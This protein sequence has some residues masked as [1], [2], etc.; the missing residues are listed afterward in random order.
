MTTITITLQDKK[1]FEETDFN[2]E[3]SPETYSDYINGLKTDDKI[4]PSYNFL[5]ACVV[6]DE[7]DALK[8][9]LK[10][11]GM[12]ILMAQKVLE[13]YMPDVDVLVKK[14]KA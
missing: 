9:E 5:M 6:D 4:A 14:S 13:E 8:A 11:P 12:P 10:K 3:V 2:F 1:T 7:K